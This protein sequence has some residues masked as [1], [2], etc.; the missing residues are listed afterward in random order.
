MGS[1][2]LYGAT[3]GYLELQ[4]PDVAPDAALV[5]PSTGFGKILQVVSTTKTDTF[6]ASVAQGANTAITGLSVS[7]TPSSATSKVLVQASVS[8]G[9]PDGGGVSSFLY[10]FRG[11]TQIGLGDT[12]SNRTPISSGVFVDASES[13]GSVPILFLDSPAT[14][15]ATTYS[16]NIGH[17]L[18]GT[19]T[20]NVNRNS[21]DTDFNYIPRAVSTITVME[22]SA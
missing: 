11:V 18:G 14:T 3:S 17:G 12:A 19:T 1:V 5:L 15:S 4:A 9:K 20:V 2:R 21:S 10:L 6:T 13:L 22:V 16:I 7:I 8:V